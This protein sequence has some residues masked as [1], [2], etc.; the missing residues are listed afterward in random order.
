VIAAMSD[1]AEL[2]STPNIF[3]VIR[4]ISFDDEN[5]AFSKS[6]ASTPCFG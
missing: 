3:S 1:L 5:E 4:F 6:A 2:I